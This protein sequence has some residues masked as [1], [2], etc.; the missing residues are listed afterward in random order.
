MVITVIYEPEFRK[1]FEKVKDNT[2]KEKVIKQLLK[3]K[4]DPEVG[5]PMRYGRKGTREVYVSH[6]RLSYMYIKE[7]EKLLLLDIYHKDQQ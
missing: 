3:I 4:E 2:F 7:E 1:Q 5:K 6:Y